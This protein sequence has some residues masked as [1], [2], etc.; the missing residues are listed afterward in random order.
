MIL[1]ALDPSSTACGFAVFDGLRLV[2]H[3]TVTRG[4]RML[5]DYATTCAKTILSAVT[6]HGGW[7]P[8]VW[9]ETN[10]RQTIPR[11]RQRSM[12]LQAQGAGRILQ[13]LGVEGHEKQADSRTKERRARDVALIYGLGN[14]S[15]HA[16]DAVALGHSIATDPKR[17]ARLHD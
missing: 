13:A 6:S 1:V 11:E 17:L 12:R 2:D 16:K 15:E 3:G 10:D 4:K 5:T 8:E 9:Y 7:E 14:A